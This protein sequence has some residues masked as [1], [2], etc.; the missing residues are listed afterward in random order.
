M[1]VTPNVVGMSTTLGRTRRGRENSLPP[2]PVDDKNPSTK[3]VRSPMAASL[4]RKYLKRFLRVAPEKQPVPTSQFRSYRKPSPSPSPTTISAPMALATNISPSHSRTDAGSKPPPRPPS[5]SKPASPF[6][7]QLSSS[8]DATKAYAFEFPPTNT[9]SFAGRHATEPVSP[10]PNSSASVGVFQD[11]PSVSKLV[12]GQTYNQQC[13]P[14]ELP[15]EQEESRIGKTSV[16]PRRSISRRHSIEITDVKKHSSKGPVTSSKPQLAPKPAN[17]SMRTLGRPFTQTGS[18]T[19]LPFSQSDLT[20]RR[21][22]YG[23]LNRTSRDFQQPIDLLSNQESGY[24]KIKPRQ[25]SSS[26]SSDLCRSPPTRTESVGRRSS[27]ASS[28]RS[29]TDGSIKSSGNSS[30]LSKLPSSCS[31]VSASLSPNRGT[32]DLNLDPS[33]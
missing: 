17:L 7:P 30:S 11:S 5:E 10:S 4:D 31:T 9:Q 26:N 1:N 23:S 6:R 14:L 3:V 28:R 15:L 24:A 22:P 25:Q 16:S 13:N 21:G 20:H 29:S 32:V 12:V 33:G 27:V 19:N 18:S 8:S 2:V